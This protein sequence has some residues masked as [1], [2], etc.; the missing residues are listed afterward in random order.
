MYTS[1]IAHAL[2]LMQFS[3][4]VR[5]SAYVR[6]GQGYCGGNV[7]SVHVVV[8]VLICFT[9]P[10]AAFYSFAFVEFYDTQSAVKWMDQNRVHVHAVHVELR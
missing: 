8:C 3:G 5:S 10:P 7:I 9:P 1:Y 6:R 2:L 4:S